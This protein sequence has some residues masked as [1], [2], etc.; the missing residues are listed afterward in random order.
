MQGSITRSMHLCPF[1][2]LRYA[3]G[4][5]VV[6]FF[7]IDHGLKLEVFNIESTPKTGDFHKKSY[8]G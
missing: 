7:T 8:F 5:A 1:I 2:V 6:H 3:A 4:Q